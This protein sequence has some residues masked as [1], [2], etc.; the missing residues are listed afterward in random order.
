M[1][2]D[3]LASPPAAHDPFAQAL[4]RVVPTTE[5]QREIWLADHLDREASL[6][7]NEA[8][9][10]RIEGMLDHA[11]LKQALQ[12]LAQRHDALHSVLSG[13]GQTLCVLEQATL[14]LAVEDLSGLDLLAQSERL[15]QA[16][17]AAVSHPFDLQDGPLFRAALYRIGPQSHR[18]LLS[19]HH[20]I[21]DGWSWW[22]IVR[23]LGALY[24][25]ALQ[26]REASLPPVESFADHALAEASQS[27]QSTAATE[28]Y[29]RGRFADGAPVLELPIDLPRPA[30]R[31]FSSR[32]EDLD[33]PPELLHALRE[34]AAKQGCSLFS[35]MLSAFALLVARIA[36]QDDVVIGIPSA[37]Q[38][39]SGKLAMVGH[40]AN[41]LPM[42]FAPNRGEA[43]S[44]FLKRANDDLLDAVEHRD[45]TLSTLLQ[46]LAIARDPSRV[47]LAPVLFNIDQSLDGESAAFAGARIECHGVARSADN[48]ELS[49]NAVQMASGL[50]LE[51]QYATSL[52]QST[53]VRRWLRAYRS[54][55]QGVSENIDRS[56]SD[57]GLL[58]AGDLGELAALS[59]AA[60]PFQR[61]RLMHQHFEASCDRLPDAV[62]A[63]DNQRSIRYR[64]LEHEANRIAHLLI[65][66]GV[67]PGDLVGL[68]VERGISMLASMLGILKAGAGYIP[69]DPAFP[70]ARLQHMLDDGG[71]SAVLTTLALVDGLP[72]QGQRVVLLDAATLAAQPDTRPNLAGNPEAIAYVIYTSGSTGTPKGVEIPHRAVANFLGSMATQPGLRSDD[73]LIAVTTLSFDIAVLE[74]MLPLHVGAQVVIVDRDTTLDGGALAACMARHRA[75]VMQATPATWRML[76]EAEWTGGAGFRI[77]CGGEPLPPTLA[78]QLLARCGEL[79]NVY[80]PT[81]TT[82]WSTCARIMTPARGDLPDIHIGKPI[83]NTGVWILDDARQPCVRG[84]PGEL[85]ISG[86]GLARG[87]RNQPALTADRFID[88]NGPDGRVRLYRT[89]DRA[90]W[91]DDG[92]LEHQG[93]LDHQVKLRGYRIEL[94]EIETQLVAHPD[95]QSA[96]AMVREEREGDARLVAYVVQEPDRSIDPVQM[97]KHLR[98]TLPE[99]MIPQ[100]IVVL[101]HWPLTANGKIDRKALPDPE[102]P[103][104]GDDVRATPETP[105]QEQLLQAF[106]SVLRISAIGIDDD[107]FL[108]G[109]HSLLAAQLTTRLNKEL[110]LALSQRTL[111]DA[112]SV[113]RL[114]AK[115]EG[116]QGRGHAAST[117]QNVI[118]HRPQQE[119]APLS[120]LQNRQALIHEFHPEVLAYSLPSGHRL[121][122]PLDVANFRQALIN[123]VERQTVLRTVFERRGDDLVQVVRHNMDAHVLD[124][125]VD[126]AHL[127]PGQRQ[128]ALETDIRT[129]VARPFESLA[130]AP[131]F[132]S[133]LYR[134]A[135]DEH[136]WFFMPHQIIWDGWSFDLLYVELSECYVALCEGRPPRLPELPVTYGDYAE[137]HNAWMGSAAY[138]RQREQWRKWMCTPNPRGGWPC[139]LP[140]DRPRRRLMTGTARAIPLSLSQAQSDALRQ[141]ARGMDSTVFVVMLAA[142]F[143]ALADYNGDPD[144]VVGMPV[145][146]RNHAETEPLMGH[147][148]NLLP[149]RID[150]PVDGALRDVVR[151]AKASL[152]DSL[153]APDIQL[154]DIAEMRA[155]LPGTSNSIL[156]HAQFSF[157]DIRDRITHWGALSHQR[158][159]IDQPSISEDLNLW[160][161]DRGE[162]GLQGTLLYNTDLLEPATA[163]RIARYYE[164]LLAAMIADPERAIDA[165]LVAIRQATNSTIS[166]DQETA[167]AMLLNNS[168]PISNDRLDYVRSLWARHLG[169]EVVAGDNFFDLGGSSMLAI[170]MLSEM[171][172]DTGVKMKL[173][174]LAV[175]T[176]A[177]VAGKLPERSGEPT[178]SGW[179]KRIF[180]RQ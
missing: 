47:P 172:R 38:P 118:V 45:Y 180:G 42:R 168:K 102:I 124:P 18:L 179:F 46:Q 67:K 148:V 30:H 74:L 112:P 4:L 163:N 81:E 57:Y 96:I 20:V 75:T 89:G 99:Y 92:M 76:I 169:T 158:L 12:A 7:Y 19:A 129:L 66:Q 33:L 152:L 136:V 175:Q 91:R 16:E 177:E 51:C 161:V 95:V 84:V 6:A 2:V 165:T 120:I 53:T 54:L 11:A 28:R 144:I 27:T 26:G 149:V 159:D 174:E 113:R 87:Y 143:V 106:I 139:A 65:G 1:T 17:A 25:A 140:T 40:C 160:V 132:R 13:D 164:Q 150:V 151:L 137:W 56:C 104:D 122:G 55:L 126:L 82:V 153:S 86:A 121:N 115:I 176:A 21:C 73:V 70:Q 52:L 24:G 117:A 116:E 133:R 98:D 35:L 156:Y 32:R 63:S 8:L 44:A 170:K 71:P 101:A 162:H 111:F 93:R 69:L 77:L 146:G 59:P 94:G 135:E 15:A 10:I 145:R 141:I 127:A 105:L 83:A 134:M 78:A 23:D 142:Y 88:W 107:F 58:D 64:E 167:S 9:T 43:F 85:C 34:T 60:T 157:Q 166:P 62:A 110:S 103:V 125:V 72:L 14:P 37:G 39:A 138:Q 97:K 178:G 61:E 79:W 5:G 171:L 109:G 130:E 36:G 41:T 68:A 154:E 50:R 29:W 49:L 100:H 119:C 90:R 155:G 173:P 22:V 114:A 108:S 3:T 131:L 128:S 147:I 123:V 48:F 80:G 31:H